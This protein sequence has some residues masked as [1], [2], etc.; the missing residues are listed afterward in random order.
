MSDFWRLANL[1]WFLFS[2]FL[3]VGV[4][5]AV[6]GGIYFY[7]RVDESI[8]RQVE[9][10]LSQ[11][12]PEL[13]INVN[14]AR[15][16]E[17]EGFEIGGI[18]LNQKAMD[19]AAQPL[20]YIDRVFIRCR[21]TLEELIHRQLQIS[22]VIIQRPIVRATRLTDGSWTIRRLGRLPSFGGSAAPV[23]QVENGVLEIVDTRRP[24]SGLLTMR[25]I[26]LR[27]APAEMMDDQKQVAI[28]MQGTLTGDYCRRILLSGTLLPDRPWAN[29]VGD[30]QGL[31][32][33]PQL[34]IALPLQ[35]A[36][37]LGLLDRLNA[38]GHARF[39]LT[40]DPSAERPL[41]YHLG[42]GVIDGRVDDPRLPLPLTNLSARFEASRDDVRIEDIRGRCGSGTATV[43]CR[44]AGPAAHAPWTIEGSIKRLRLEP[45]ISEKLP[46]HL[47]AWWLKLRPIGLVSA[48]FHFEVS[49][50]RIIP[51]VDIECHETGFTWHQFPY[52]VDQ[53]A[54][55]I[56]V[57]PDEVHFELASRHAKQPLWFKGEI[58]RPGPRWH[59]WCEAKTVGPLPFDEALVAAATPRAQQVI[60]DFQPRG[61][62]QGSLR[63]ERGPDTLLEDVRMHLTVSDGWVRHVRFPYPLHEVT[64]DIERHNDQW[65]FVDFRGRN[66]R[67]EITCHGNWQADEDAGGL[68]FELLARSLPMEE[69]LHRS[70]D[71]S[72]QKIWN[73]LRP[74][75]SLDEVR[76]SYRYDHASRRRRMTVGIQ[77]W[78]Q[79][80]RYAQLS[81]FPTA[82]PYRLDNVSGTVEVQDGDIRLNN[83]RAEH[84]SVRALAS[85]TARA[86]PT[87]EWKLHFDQ[88]TA[89]QVHADQE[90]VAALPIPIRERLA[91]LPARSRFAPWKSAIRGTGASAGS[92]CPLE[93]DV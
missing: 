48:D 50:E 44:R 27:F 71:P 12:Y 86:E 38:R 21:P 22:E 11:Q 30:V 39:Q 20:A 81:F 61:S 82:F 7:H 1:L 70:L 41:T 66:D 80:D 65:T 67:G 6:L 9:V 84:G 17:R 4:V 83:L 37:E 31:S 68:S 45:G 25:D 34:R 79:H 47:Q 46:V 73:Q 62:V 54:G 26:N 15:L 56:S 28:H 74:Q 13:E 35:V 93:P 33:S 87:G 55:V 40:Y 53:T 19:V 60:R 3:L 36:P 42:G 72:A 23:V 32:W 59:G 91:H 16:L 24:N 52:P 75:G 85:G 76:V 64:G 92:R 10:L 29:L 63:V 57:R 8:R 14:Y 78:P 89:D 18:S 69:E 49:D 43:S 77:K 2:W 58:H 88:L 90:L 51:R 5:C